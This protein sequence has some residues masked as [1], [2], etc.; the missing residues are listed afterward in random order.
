ML[1]VLCFTAAAALIV[2]VLMDLGEDETNPI[3][4]LGHGLVAIVLLWAGLDAS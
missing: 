2:N 3:Q 4:A 1:P